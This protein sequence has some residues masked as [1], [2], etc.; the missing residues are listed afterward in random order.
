MTE[1]RLKKIADKLQLEIVRGKN[2]MGK[3]YSRFVIEQKLLQ[4][5]SCIAQIGSL[6]YSTIHGEIVHGVAK[7]L[8]TRSQVR[9]KLQIPFQK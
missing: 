5:R 1:Q 3:P 9:N 8:K 7:G 2:Y 4:L 6:W